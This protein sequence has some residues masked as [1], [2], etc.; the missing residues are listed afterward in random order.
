MLRTHTLDRICLEPKNSSPLIAPQATAIERFVQHPA[1]RS[2][3]A[4]LVLHVILLVL[5]ALF[6]IESRWKRSRSPL[7]IEML[8]IGNG[9]QDSPAGME[10]V[11]FIDA[12]SILEE[13][14]SMPT[15]V[16]EN[17][18]VVTD[19][20]LSEIIETPDF[21]DPTLSA[22]ILLEKR[23]EAATPLA[24][25][26][27]QP[28][29]TLTTHK[30]AVRSPAF[31]ARRGR[32]RGD[33]VRAR[34]GSP[35]SEAAVERGL[36]WLAAHQSVDGSWRCDLSDCRCNGA[37]SNP[38]TI[39]STTAST[40]I[41]LLPFLG[42]GSTHQ[43]GPYRETVSRGFYYLFSRMQSTPRGGDFCE[44][45]LYG[46]G[47][48]MLA[49]A[50]AY[51]MTSDEAFTPYAE[52]AI[53]YIETSQDLHTGGW[54]YLPGQAGDITVTGWQLAA[55]KSA[56][57]AGLAVPSPTIEGVVRFLDRVSSADGSAYGYRTPSAK[58][59]TSAIGLLS[60]M[61]T[62]WPA[63][64][65]SIQRGLLRIAAEGPSETSLYR[66]FYLSQALLQAN[67][68]SWKRWN[69]R[70]RDFLVSRQHLRHHETGSW[71][72]QD[73]DIAPGGRL[74]HTAL[75]ILTLEVYYRVLPIYGAD[76]IVDEF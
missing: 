71:F 56:R 9:Q 5:L 69:A 75:A 57:L 55:L 3:Y 60:R 68:H 23:T 35:A 46:Q 24:P 52:A 37:C 29:S 49:M 53:R 20:T 27:S 16:T 65:K 59:S 2:G 47:L 45:T 39:S 10:G 58:A 1:V 61:Y 15:D 13:A 33:A 14:T 26:P 18:I 42:A 25:S 4:S 31:D 63:A 41:A 6:A 72:F 22:T 12:A 67:H 54:R 17:Q 50:E 73:S 30:A 11:E 51:G 74:A 76:A 66:D 44:G 70:T 43:E 36:A 38:G 21:S 19:S 8:S 32:A 34:G 40:A 64:H 48:P 62:G 28:H 7:V